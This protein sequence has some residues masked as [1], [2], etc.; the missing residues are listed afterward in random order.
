[1][2]M[3]FRDKF[4][5]WVET[6][7]VAL[8]V[9]LV[10]DVLWQVASRYIMKDPS[11]FTDELAGFL[12]IWVGLIGSAY[13]TGKHGHLAIDLAIQRL[14]PTNRRLVDILINSS[15]AAFAFSVMVIGGTWLVYTRFLL[16]QTS[17][18]LQLPY[19]F[20]YLVL[21]IS[22]LIIMYYTLDDVRIIFNSKPE[23]GSND[24]VEEEQ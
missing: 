23:N 8:M 18:A 24:K 14:K 7:V 10:V 13:T 19:G 9:L 22:G 4:D 12:L 11:D 21:P 1:M 6:G 2:I 3:K 16:N 20:V 17:S 5:R 15:I